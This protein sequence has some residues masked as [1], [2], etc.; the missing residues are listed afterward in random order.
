MVSGLTGKVDAQL[1][2]SMDGKHWERG[3]RTPLFANGEPGTPTAGLVYP[4]SALDR[5]CDAAS[6]FQCVAAAEQNQTFTAARDG[7]DDDILLFAS[8]SSVEHG[9]MSLDSGNASGSV[10]TY[11]LRRDGWV[12]LT[13]GGGVG[14]LGTRVLEWGG[15]GNLSLNVNARGGE[16]RVQV[17]T[18]DDN[19]PLPGMSF[20]DCRVFTGDS[21]SWIPQ[22]GGKS[23]GAFPNNR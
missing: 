21:T 10:L 1:A 11:S 9:R 12:S 17:S 4:N 16:A 15:R 5:T 19:L 13:N 2:W 3:I 18:P 7:R 23:T 14:R 20:A 6:Q 8:A 22:W